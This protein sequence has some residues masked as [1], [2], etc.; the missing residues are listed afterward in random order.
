LKH[1]L[2]HARAVGALTAA[3]ALTLLAGAAP[4]QAHDALA[5]TSPADGTTITTNPGTVSVTLTNAPDTRIPNSNI[6]KVTA[7]DGHVVSEGEVTLED[8]TLSVAADIDHDGVHTVDWRAVSA[9]GHPIEGTFS[10]TYTPTGS[11]T[12]TP[13]ATESSPATGPATQAVTPAPAT[14]TPAPAS[15]QTAQDNT[16]LLIGVGAVLLILIAVGVYLFRR[17]AKA[18]T[19]A[20]S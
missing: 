10:F 20:S 7:P 17:R 16:G 2:P 11:D 15:S 12:H 14:E 1:S 8:A 19:G 5:S 18:G 9:D 4:A 6:I 3:L 13:A